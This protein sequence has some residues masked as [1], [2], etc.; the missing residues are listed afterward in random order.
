[1]NQRLKPTRPHGLR[2][3]ALTMAVAM[4]AGALAG[5][6]SG[7]LED[8]TGSLGLALTAIVL[9]A[10]MAIGMA[11]CLWWWRGIDEAAREAHKW[12]WWWGG[13]GGLA[14]GAIGLLT[15]TVRPGTEG[16]PASFGETSADIFASGMTSVV[17]CQLVGYVIAWAGW[18]LK[19]R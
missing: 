7:F 15:L 13:S 6:G 2:A 19:H 8:R 10:A 16:L 11:V 9:T 3:F 5:L 18:W 4:L 1:M 17:L 12:A 14:V